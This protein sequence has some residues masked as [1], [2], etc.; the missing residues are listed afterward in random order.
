MSAIKW[1]VVSDKGR[2]IALVIGLL[3]VVMVGALMW[4]RLS[5]DNVKVAPVDEVTRNFIDKRLNSAKSLPEG[6]FLWFDEY[7]NIALYAAKHGDCQRAKEALAIIDGIAQ[8]PEEG[9]PD[10]GTTIKDVTANVYATC[11]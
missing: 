7:M 1:R 11:K 6:T 9:V 2:T 8:Q 10:I 5:A 4:W 3:I